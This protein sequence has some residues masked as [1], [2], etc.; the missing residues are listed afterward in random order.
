[1]HN[2]F[3]EVIYMQNKQNLHIHTNL[4]DGAD[5]P[6]EMVLAALSTGFDSIGFSAHSYMNYSDY[7]GDIDRTE[8]YKKEISKLKKNLVYFITKHMVP[9][10]KLS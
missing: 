10:L 9:E 5:S 3:N 8:E 1:M 6:E 2:R 4:C 7:L